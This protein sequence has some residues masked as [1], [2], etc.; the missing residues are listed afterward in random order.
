V[1]YA[2]ASGAIVPGLRISLWGVWATSM[3]RYSDRRPH[4]RYDCAGLPLPPKGG[5][6]YLHVRV[7]CGAKT[8]T[9]PTRPG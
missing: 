6:S 2:V 5:G 4:I 9:R 3:L 7:L 8:Q 1:Q